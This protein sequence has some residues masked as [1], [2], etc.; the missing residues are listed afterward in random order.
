MP[1][2]TSQS[3]PGHVVRLSKERILKAWKETCHVQEILSKIDRLDTMDARRQQDGIFNVLERKRSTKNSL[4]G[5]SREV[6]TF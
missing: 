6:K 1:G 2:S 3:T 5:K 4:S